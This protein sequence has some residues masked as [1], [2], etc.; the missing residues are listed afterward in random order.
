[1][2][3]FIRGIPSRLFKRLWFFIDTITPNLSS[4]ALKIDPEKSFL[5]EAEEIFWKWTPTQKS[6]SKNTKKEKIKKDGR[7]RLRK[8]TFKF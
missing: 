4:T 1:M 2:R 7:N 3:S 6:I 5:R 8:S